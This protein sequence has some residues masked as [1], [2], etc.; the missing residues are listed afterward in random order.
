MQFQEI[1]PEFN[2]D[3]KYSPDPDA[4]AVNV[5][6]QDANRFCELLSAREGAIYQ[7]P[8]ENVFKKP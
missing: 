1:I 3:R 7:L 5:S 6:W 2:V 4:P 8:T